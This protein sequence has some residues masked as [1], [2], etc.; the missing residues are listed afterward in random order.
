MNMNKPNG[1]DASTDSTVP[2]VGQPSFNRLA[3][4]KPAAGTHG[5]VHAGAKS[6]LAT[7]KMADEKARARTLARVQAVSEKLST[8]TE[9]V[10]SAITES[11][12]AVQELEKTMQSIATQTQQASAA[13]EESRAAI[14]QIEKAS[15]AAPTRR[16][17]S[18][19]KRSTP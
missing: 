7:K 6:T 15:D 9:E 18:P 14:N 11:T 13:A 2:P 19:C 8:A 3:S 16:R 5:A 10:G 1:L 17:K 12:S 4:Q